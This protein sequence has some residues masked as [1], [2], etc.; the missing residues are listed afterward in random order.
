MEKV[1]KQRFM[2]MREQFKTFWLNNGAKSQQ[3]TFIAYTEA[4][5]KD[6]SLPFISRDTIREYVKEFKNQYLITK[7]SPKILYFDIETTDLMAGFGIMLMVSYCYQ[8][9]PADVKCITILDDLRYKDLPPEKCDKYLVSALKDLI[10][11]SDIQVAHFGSKFDIK[12]LQ[13]RLLIHR[14]Q[15]TDSKWKT[16][17]DTCITAWKKFK[18]G[19]RLKVLARAMGCDNQKDELPLSV[20]QRSK[21]IGYEPYFSDA[22]KEMVDYC[23]QDT[24]TLYDIAQPMFPYAKHLP[25]FQAITGV[26]GNY[27]PSVNCGSHNIEF[28]GVDPTKSGA[29]PQYRCK[30]CG[31]IYRGT[32]DIRKF[33]KERKV[34]Y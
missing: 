20:W 17:F 24:R 12:F 2:T 32:Q 9:T 31:T 22:I 27:C 14:L 10:D 13:S 5:S 8:D 33:T 30:D 26:S 15:M 7:K 28:V 4:R 11:E 16:F 1:R 23:K 3:P 6:P 29:Y 21:C 19:G 25:S 34:A 18:I